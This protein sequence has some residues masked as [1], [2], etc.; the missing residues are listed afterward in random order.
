MT[1]DRQGG[2]AA[3]GDILHSQLH[4]IAAAQFAVDGQV[5]QG[6]VTGTVGQL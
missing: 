1:V 5:E 6:Q 2:L 3:L 4:Q